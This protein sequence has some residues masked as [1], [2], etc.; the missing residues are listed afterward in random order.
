MLYPYMSLPDGT[1]ICHSQIIDENGKK[2]VLVHFERPNDAGDFDSARCKLPSYEWIIKKGYSDE[3]ISFF[4]KL[5]ESNAHLI[6]RYAANGGVK[7]A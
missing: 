4:T 5:L 3:E 2:S 6:F 1:E 7:I